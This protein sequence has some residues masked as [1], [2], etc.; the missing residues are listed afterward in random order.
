MVQRLRNLSNI[1]KAIMRTWEVEPNVIRVEDLEF[2]DYV[3]ASLTIEAGSSI[4]RTRF[5][6]LD[7]FR[8]NLGNLKQAHL[9][10]VVDKSATLCSDI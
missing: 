8:R 6:V 1:E 3:I 4:P 5:K 7:V 2:A 9:A 10:I